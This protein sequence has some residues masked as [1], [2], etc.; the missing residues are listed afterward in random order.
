M[1]VVHN[2]VKWLAFVDPLKAAWNT[3][4]SRDTTDDRFRRQLARH[5]CPGCREDVEDIETPGERREDF[6]F[7]F[8][9]RHFKLLAVTDPPNMPGPQG[10]GFAE[11][12][13]KDVSRI[14]ARRQL[15]AGIIV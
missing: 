14:A 2:D 5:G 1:R 8:L 15:P 12:V 4:A 6:E 11:S 3:V 7:C 10:G 9:K 13:P